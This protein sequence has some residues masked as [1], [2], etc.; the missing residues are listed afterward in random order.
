M[1]KYETN[2]KLKKYWEKSTINEEDE[3][4]EEFNV[5]RVYPE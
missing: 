4:D 1:I 3:S 5:I 2:I